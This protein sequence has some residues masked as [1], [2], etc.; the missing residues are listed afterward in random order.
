[1]QFPEST[2]FGRRVPKESFYQRLDMNSTIKRAFIDDIDQIVWQNKL[3]P[4]T[5]N[6]GS[7]TRVLEIEVFYIYLKRKDYNPKLIEVIEKA[8]PKHL[9]FVLIFQEE[10]KLLINYKEESDHKKGQYKIVETYA[11]D[12]SQSA[13]IML[14]LDGLNIDQIYDGFIRQIAGL[15]IT[16]GEE[17]IKQS[18][19]KAQ[20]I[21]KLEKKIAVLEA[22]KRK[23]KQFNKQIEIS[24]EIKELNL[25]LVNINTDNIR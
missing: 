23:E 4:D 6:I 17:E 25:K 13:E 8:I 10:K 1:M 12:W 16:T 19:E 5:L 22:K 2:Y 7:G 14:S 3:S 21:V 18:V 11:S 9:L 20:A 24:K 15:R